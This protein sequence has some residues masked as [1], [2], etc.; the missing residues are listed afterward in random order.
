MAVEFPWDRPHFFIN[1]GGAVEP[2]RRPNQAMNQRALPDRDRAGHAAALEAAIGTALEE[3][4][5]Q[6]AGRDMDLAAGTPGFYLEVLVPAGERAVI[7][8]LADRRKQM[9][10]VAVREG[11]AGQGLPA[12]FPVP[13]CPRVFPLLEDAGFFSLILIGTKAVP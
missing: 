12:S 4:R 9:E 2:Y 10:V 11:D 5:L 1:G 7:D 8:Q 13:F 3:A 6:L